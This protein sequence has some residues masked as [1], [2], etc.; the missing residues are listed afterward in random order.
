M[1]PMS[2]RS[3][4]KLNTK[5]FALPR[6]AVLLAALA[7]AVLSSAC[8]PLLIGGAMVGGAMV[9][10][11]RRTSGTQLED[12]GIELKAGSRVREGLRSEFRLRAAA[13]RRRDGRRR[14]GRHRP[15][16]LGHA[17][18]GPGHRAEGRLARA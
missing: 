8:A 15:P 11:D 17:T 16:H 18:R 10:T 9:A 7:G 2:L 14:D 3:S 6:H 1:K 4:M 13:D 12:Q 5:T